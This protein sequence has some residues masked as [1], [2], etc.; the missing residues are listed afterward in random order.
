MRFIARSADRLLLKLPVDLFQHRRQKGLSLFSKVYLFHTLREF[1]CFRLL[2]PAII[3]TIGFVMNTVFSARSCCQNFIQTLSDGDYHRWWWGDFDLRSFW[4]RWILGMRCLL[5]HDW[6][7]K[8][9]A[10]T[11]RGGGLTDSAP[12]QWV[13]RLAIYNG[14]KLA[15]RGFCSILANTLILPHCECQ[16]YQSPLNFALRNRCNG[17]G[18]L[19]GLFLVYRQNIFSLTSFEI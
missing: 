4:W 15:V 3:S 11:I 7:A 12:K 6:R 9:A 1:K 14:P 8:K 13:M 10:E 5:I 17:A 19:A 16:A 18:S 2:W